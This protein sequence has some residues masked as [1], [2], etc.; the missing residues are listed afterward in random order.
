MYTVPNRNSVHSI[1]NRPNPRRHVN[2][3]INS[4]TQSKLITSQL[5]V[6]IAPRTTS[7]Y[8]SWS[9]EME[10]LL[11]AKKCTQVLAQDFMTTLRTLTLKDKHE[12]E[13]SSTKHLELFNVSSIQLARRLLEEALL[14]KTS[15]RHSRISWKAR[16]LYQDLFTD[17]SLHNQGRRRIS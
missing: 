14:P 2:V 3:S 13:T 12:I 11:R 7:T 16:I 5:G 15:V 9:V 4:Q 10:A 6:S 1:C 8:A 17:P